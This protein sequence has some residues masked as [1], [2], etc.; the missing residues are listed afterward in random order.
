MGSSLW[1][2]HQADDVDAALAQVDPAVAE[3]ALVLRSGL[4]V[5]VMR[6]GVA[7]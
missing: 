2:A 7:S 6:I 3:V 4:D 1:A 5:L